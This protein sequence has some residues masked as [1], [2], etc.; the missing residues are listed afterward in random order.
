MKD[1]SDDPSHSYHGATSRSLSNNE[2]LVNEYRYIKDRKVLQ[3]YALFGCQSLHSCSG[4][5]S[6]SGCVTC[7][8]NHF[9]CLVACAIVG[10]HKECAFSIFAFL[11]ILPVVF[12]LCV[13]HWL[14][15]SLFFSFSEISYTHT[16]THT[17]IHTHTHLFN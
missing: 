2:S 4:F 17:H 9:C 16:H 1:H 11:H 3:V 15:F 13:L 12:G 10:V 5:F 8:L 14:S 7:H 6:H